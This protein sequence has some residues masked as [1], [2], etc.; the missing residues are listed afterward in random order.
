MLIKGQI[1][2][3]FSLRTLYIKDVSINPSI[4]KGFYELSRAK[5][6]RSLAEAKKVVKEES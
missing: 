1:K 4:V 2:P 3:P 5:Y 6:S